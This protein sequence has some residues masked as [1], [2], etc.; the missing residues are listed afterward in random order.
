M[1]KR[2]AVSFLCV[3]CA[4]DAGGKPFKDRLSRFHKG[5][6]GVCKQARAVT[7]PS[8]FKWV[9]QFEHKSQA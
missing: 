1:N 4:F 5:V 7:E 3:E 6:C 9:R 8:D 2:P